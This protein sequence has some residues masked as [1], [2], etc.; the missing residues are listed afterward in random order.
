MM[1]IPGECMSPS[2]CVA[3]AISRLSK[4]G[5]DIMTH[6]GDAGLDG[7]LSLWIGAMGPFDITT[8]RQRG[9][10]LR[11]NFNQPLDSR[12]VDHFHC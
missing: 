10:V 2:H 5:C 1:P 4:D 11:A 6:P 8:T 12:I 7:S 3:V 9:N